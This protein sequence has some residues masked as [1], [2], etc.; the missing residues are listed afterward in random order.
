MVGVFHSAT[1]SLGRSRT[2]VSPTRPLRNQAVILRAIDQLP[3]VEIRAAR[4]AARPSRTLEQRWS[5]TR[6]GQRAALVCYSHGLAS[7]FTRITSA[8]NRKDRPAYVGEFHDLGMQGA[9]AGPDEL[10]VPKRR[11]NSGS[12]NCHNRCTT[13]PRPCHPASD[14]TRSSSTRHRISPDE[15][16]PPLLASLRDQDTGG[17]YVFSDEAQ[18]LRP[19]GFTTGSARADRAR[20]QPTQHTSIASAFSSLVGQRMQLKGGE[21]P[22]IR[23]V[24]CSAEEALE[25][26]DDHIDVLLDEGWRAEDIALLTTGSRHPEQIERQAEG[27]ASYWATF[28][29]D[30]QVFYDYRTRLQGAGASSNCLGAQRV[31][32]EEP[33]DGTVVCRAVACTRATRGVRRSRVRADSRRTRG[34]AT[35]GHRLTRP[36]LLQLSTS[37]GPKISGRTA[38]R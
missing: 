31:P 15:W 24:A 16:W 21:G 35:A 17:I 11:R 9:A 5:P 12:M 20:S 33:V 26:A 27:N 36:T 23:F 30:E 18:R 4:A 14:S 28:W 22:D 34:R 13:S 2:K 10:R 37:R 32:G 38:F 29:D 8:W 1:S 25:A 19:T 3:R 7:Y 6:A